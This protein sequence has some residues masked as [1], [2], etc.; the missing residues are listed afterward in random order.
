RVLLISAAATALAFGFQFA[1]FSGGPDN[2]AIGYSTQPLHNAITEVNREIE[3]GKLRL[4]FDGPSGYLRS[5]LAALRIPVQ[6]QMLVYSKTSLQRNLISPA[7]PRSLFFNDSIAVGWVPGEPFVE[8]AADDPTQGVIFYTLDQQAADRPLFARR[9]DTCLECHESYDALGVP[10]LLVRSEYTA[11]SGAALRRLG[12][13]VTD[14]RSPF[15]ER[16]GG[17]YVTG[18]T[19]GLRH[20]GNLIF[21]NPDVPRPA[22]EVAELDSLRGKVDTAPYLSPYSDVVALLVFD[23]QMR[24]INLFTSAGWEVRSA[25]RAKR[26]D[27]GKLLQ[28]AAADLADYLLFVDEAPLPG[29]IEGTSGFAEEFASRGPRDRQ[30]RSL[31]QFDLERRLM[32]FPCSYMIYSAAFED[33]PPELKD[34]IYR[35]MWR[36]LSGQETAPKYA[37]LTFTDRQAVVEILRATKPG[38]PAYFQEIRS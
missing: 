24:M 21:P 14:H 35:R 37:R 13:F 18:R 22:A 15:E 3:D 11:P 23:H 17:W 19:G 31:R 9:G 7:N 1:G 34:A 33:L 30:G 4:A 16:W 6:S 38:L 26:A 32:R 20:M 29:R 5:V 27:I 10:G 28:Q 12:E 2:P 8:V 25:L 36:V